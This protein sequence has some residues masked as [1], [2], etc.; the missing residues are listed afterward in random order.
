M[1]ATPKQFVFY[2]DAQGQW[3][4]TLYALNSKKIADSAEGYNNL[5]DCRHGATLVAAVATNSEHWNA[6]TKAWM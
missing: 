5:A 3:R 1:N 2:K 4:W 6:E